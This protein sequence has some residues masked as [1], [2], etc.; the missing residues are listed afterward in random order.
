VVRDNALPARGVARPIEHAARSG[1]EACG[2]HCGRGRS[3]M[4]CRSFPPASAELTQHA[5]RVRGSS[6]FPPRGHPGESW[7]S[8]R[9]GQ[10][11]AV[12]VAVAGPVVAR[13]AR[14]NRRSIG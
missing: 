9:P 4:G 8:A 5:R 12:A 2:E 10:E 13:R 14:P 11:R 1:A 3:R 7:S 6:R